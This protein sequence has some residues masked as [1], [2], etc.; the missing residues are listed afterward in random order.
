M[1]LLSFAEANREI[2]AIT[3]PNRI[4]DKVEIAEAMGCIS[5][6]VNFDTTGHAPQQ[7]SRVINITIK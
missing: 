2:E 6:A 5:F 7:I 1:S 4:P 3:K